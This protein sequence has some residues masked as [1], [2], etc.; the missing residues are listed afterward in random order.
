MANVRV[1]VFIKGR[2]QGIGFR[3]WIREQARQ[4][5]LAGWARNLADGRVE[6]VFEGPKDKVEEM[7]KRCSKGPL[8]ASVGKIDFYKEKASGEFEGF[9]IARE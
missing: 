1:H 7:I 4:L 2:V 9:E 6:A 8:F 3:Y 5:D